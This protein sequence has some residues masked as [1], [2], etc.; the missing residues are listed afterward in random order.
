MEAQPAPAPAPSIASYLPAIEKLLGQILRA[1][2]FELSFVIRKTASDQAD[3]EAPEFIVELPGPDSDL[4]LEKH[5]A[6]L[7]ALEYVVLR[8]V[9]LEEE[10]FGKITFDC[11]G[12]RHLRAEELK[13]MA[14]VA[15]QRVVETGDPFALSPMSPRERRIVHLALREQPAVRTASEG[16]GPAERKVI[17]HP[18]SAPPRS[19][20]R[21]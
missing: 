7:D 8:A 17:I 20:R 4:L 11:Q 3:I 19:N 18:A 9:R 21:P 14:Q 15:A 16:T 12:W 10:L 1:G 5:A 13:L 6:F 2:R